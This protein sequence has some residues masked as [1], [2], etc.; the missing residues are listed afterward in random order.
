MRF[1][2]ITAKTAPIGTDNLANLIQAQLGATGF[3]GAMIRRMADYPAQRPTSYR[4]TGSL[5]RN[6]RMRGPRN[7]GNQIIVEATNTT[8]YAVFVEGPK[9]G[10]RGH[11]QAAVMKKKGWPN[12]TDAAAAE[13]PKHQ[14]SIARILTQQDPR[15]RRRR[16]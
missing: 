4:R 16:I 7:T 8:G 2:A 1:Q 10:G 3:A 14:A 12:I 6:W 15:V 11:Q 9:T 5:G 13:W